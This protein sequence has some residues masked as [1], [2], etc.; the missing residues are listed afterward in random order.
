MARLYF[1][2]IDISI[3]GKNTFLVWNAG[4]KAGEWKV[5]WRNRKILL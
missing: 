5:L 1:G 2:G 4:T 3:E